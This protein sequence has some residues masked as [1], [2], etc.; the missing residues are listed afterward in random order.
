MKKEK[1]GKRRKNEREEK[2]AIFRSL[3]LEAQMETSP[4]GV[5]IVDSSGKI[6][7]SNRKFQKMWNI[8]KKIMEKRSALITIEWAKQKV[9]EPEEFAQKIKWLNDHLMEKK[10]DYIELKDG[11]IFSRYNFPLMSPK[12]IY[13]GRI[14][15]FADIT[16]R[17]EREKEM[18]LYLKGFEDSPNPMFLVKYENN[19]P[20]I[21][22]IN[23]AFTDYYHFTEKDALG[24]NPRILSSGKMSKE[25]YKEMWAAILDPKRGRWRG[26]IINKA[27][28]GRLLY[29]I[30]N[31]NTIFDEN[32]KPQY[33]ISSYTDITPLK[34]ALEL[35][36]KNAEDAQKIAKMRADFMNMVSHELKTPITAISAN[37][38]LLEEM[39]RNGQ[40]K[41]QKELSEKERRNGGERTKLL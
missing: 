31:T 17:K 33:F 41:D 38:E 30:L 35:I 6:I 39:K 15:Y 22:K 14:L 11:R 27:K 36:K 13:C 23:K 34:R 21:S 26:E 28:D 24:K 12:K 3:L 9:K 18:V 4:Y 29:G 40:G 25:Y 8:P 5:L 19:E 20:K 7:L 2:E 32:N 37:L 16:E 10:R 1:A